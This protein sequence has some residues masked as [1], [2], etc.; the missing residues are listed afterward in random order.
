MKTFIRRA[1]FA[2]LLVFSTAYPACSASISPAR[3]RALFAIVFGMFL[4]ILAALVISL[5]LGL[6]YGK[7]FHLF[8]KNRR[9]NVA[10]SIVLGFSILQIL[11][12]IF[13][14]DIWIFLVGIIM[15][16]ILHYVCKPD[17]QES[18]QEEWE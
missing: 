3:E 1:T 18:S 9:K 7:M 12:G 5:L 15:L 13:T 2:L 10:K 11:M 17:P 6:C 16:P 4:G 14:H 8:T